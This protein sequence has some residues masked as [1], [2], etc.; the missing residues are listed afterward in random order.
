MLDVNNLAEYNVQ[1]SLV[2]QIGADWAWYEAETIEINPGETLGVKFPLKEK[3]W[4][5]AD[6]GWNYNT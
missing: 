5:S 4:K 2:L 6:T 1:I 3:V